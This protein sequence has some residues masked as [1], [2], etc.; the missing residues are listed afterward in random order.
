MAL[1][2][3]SLAPT[4]KTTAV[5]DWTDWGKGG[6]L[7]DDTTKIIIIMIVIKEMFVFPVVGGE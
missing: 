4:L 2:L 1:L 3:E 7:L 5:N 6:T